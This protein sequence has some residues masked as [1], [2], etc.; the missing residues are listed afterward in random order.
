VNLSWYSLTLICPI[1]RF[2]NSSCFSTITLSRIWRA[3]KSLT[4]SFQ[5]TGGALSGRATWYDSHQVWV[6]PY[7][8]PDAYNTFSRSLHWAM[9]NCFSTAHTQ[10]SA[11]N[12]S[13]AWENTEGRPFK[14]SPHLSLTWTGGGPPA[15][16]LFCRCCINI[17]I[18]WFYVFMSSS[19]VMG[20]LTPPRPLPR[21]L[22]AICFQSTKD[23]AQYYPKWC[24]P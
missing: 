11:S 16:G 6:I 5:V 1:L 23:E 22:A 17:C 19:I 24:I 3:L 14:N 12:G 4:N 21:P 18:I 8:W 2:L 20:G 7:N 13:A 15:G 9:F 10:S